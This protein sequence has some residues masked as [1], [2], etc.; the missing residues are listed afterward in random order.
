MRTVKLGVLDQVK[1][2]SPCPV[3]WADM[4]GD[5]R[6]RH[7]DQCNLNVHNI[8]DMTRDEA[9]AFL[10]QAASTGG[11]V[12]AGFW[13][14]DDGTILTKDCP[15]G[16][17]AVRAA[18]ARRLSRVAAGFALVFSAITAMG[19]RSRADENRLKE[20]EPFS[21][22]ARVL[23]PVAPF[24]GPMAKPARQIWTGGVVC[25]PPPLTPKQQSP[26]RSPGT[27]IDLGNRQL[28]V[29]IFEKKSH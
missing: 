4:Q 2:A 8:S 29:D 20:M 10:V 16:L 19:M 26:T 21:G 1:I 24:L 12:C 3:A 7:C 25:L 6:T 22:I 9:E 18:F 11:R 23:S 13:R 28:G 5:D 14:R 27:N 15:V 17:A